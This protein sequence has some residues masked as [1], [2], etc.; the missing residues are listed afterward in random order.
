[1]K[2]GLLTACWL[3]AVLWTA[4]VSAG[5]FCNSAAEC[6]DGDACTQNLCIDG[7]CANPDRPQG[8]LCESDNNDCTR[9]ACMPDGL[10]GVS[11]QHVAVTFGSPCTDDG[12]DCTYDRCEPD[13]SGSGQLICNHPLVSPG[14]PCS[15]E[16][17]P[18]TF[19][20]CGF[21]PAGGP[22]SC[23]HE[24]MPPGSPCE[25][26]AN[27]CTFDVCTF[28]PSGGG[29]QCAHNALPP[30]S[31]CDD[32]NNDCTFDICGFT[33]SG[34]IDCLHNPLP[35]GATC[36]DD[37]PC[38]QIDSCD[39]SGECVGTLPHLD[40]RAAGGASIT[41]RNSEQNSRDLVDFKWTKGAAVELF[42]LGE[43]RATTD[44]TLCVFDGNGRLK[45]SASVPAGGQCGDNDCWKAT[46]KGYQYADKLRLADGVGKIKLASGVAGKS[47][48]QVRGQGRFLSPPT[49]PLAGG[50]TRVQVINDETG[51][52]FD[53]QFT[54]PKANE[55]KKFQAKTP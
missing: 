52:C 28:P 21:P 45:L 15:D 7:S 31:S 46:G 5:L 29:I 8:T 23:Q 13:P 51:V 49:L 26:D 22:I 35:P 47:Q 14:S 24:I 38:T 12:N 20:R 25:S 44:Y 43:P 53:A 55:E 39:V 19:D 3:S 50:T 6:D 32:D 17:N 10:G 1:M 11:C 27:S 2:R 34:P 18:C 4:P 54:A 41:I 40:C 33:A 30:G 36:D 48:V 9:D 42:E 16:G 37:S